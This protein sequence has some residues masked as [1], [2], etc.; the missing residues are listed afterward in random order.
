MPNDK[1]AA[2][3]PSGFLGLYRGFGSLLLQYAVQIALLVGVKYAYE[4]ILCMYSSQTPVVRQPSQSNLQHSA[5]M[6]RRSPVPSTGE[7]DTT[8]TSYG[9]TPFYSST[10]PKIFENH[11]MPTTSTVWQPNLDSERWRSADSNLNPSVGDS[12]QNS[13]TRNAFAFR[14]FNSDPFNQHMP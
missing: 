1:S 9:S 4:Y 8:N 12:G 11:P 3:S 7:Y 5:G 2:T 6:A 14:G 10:A 13:L